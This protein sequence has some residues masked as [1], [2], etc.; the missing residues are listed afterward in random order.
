[1]K[2]NYFVPEARL[3][4]IRE[5]GIVCTSPSGAISDFT[6]SQVGEGYG[7]TIEED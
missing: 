1:M 7:F 4:E 5:A 2:K 6:Y 3:L